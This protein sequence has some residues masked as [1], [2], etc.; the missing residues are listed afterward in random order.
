MKPI[1]ALFWAGEHTAGEWAGTM[2][3]A[4]RSGR[5]AAEQLIDRR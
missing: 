3:G 2:E 5:R 4:L 1:G